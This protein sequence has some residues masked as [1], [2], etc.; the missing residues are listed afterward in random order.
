MPGRAP[1]SSRSHDGDGGG[2]QYVL[3]K[4][5]RSL[6]FFLSRGTYR[7]KGSVRGWTRAA[8][9]LVAR[10]R[11]RP[12]H[13]RVWLA[14]IPLHLIFGLREASVKIEGWAFVSSNFENI[15][16]VAF[17]KHKNSKNR[18]LAPWHLV[19]RLVPKNA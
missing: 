11:G 16:C 19:N 8:H 5:D 10:A 3:W 18:E 4:I 7:R 12:R 6:R 13:A 2:L 9:P 15:S 17:L 14:P 1:G